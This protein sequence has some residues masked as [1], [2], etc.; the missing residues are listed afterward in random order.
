MELA[1]RVAQEEEAEGAAPGMTV[2]EI[3][4]DADADDVAIE[5]PAKKVPERKTKQERKKMEKLRA[6]VCS[7]FI[8]LICE[9]REMILTVGVLFR[10]AFWQSVPRKN[11]SLPPYPPQRL[12]ARIP[13]K[14]CV[15]GKP[16]YVH[17]QSS[18]YRRNLRRVSQARG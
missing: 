15:S 17:G 5:V 11:D 8:E 9:M 1:R 18:R 12:S 4:E 13:K 6:E 14:C 16:N 2:Q 10:N 7:H 3:V